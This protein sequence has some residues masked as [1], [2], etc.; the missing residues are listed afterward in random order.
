MF[1]YGSLFVLLFGVMD[2][3]YLTSCPF[4]RHMASGKRNSIPPVIRSC[5]MCGDSERIGQCFGPATCC[6]D[7]GCMIGKSPLTINCRMES[8]SGQ[9]C[10][11]YGALSCSVGAGDHV[12]QGFCSTTGVCCSDDVCVVSRKCEG[13]Q[14]ESAEEGVA[15]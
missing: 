1:L 2:A 4:R 10:I 6:F 12:R 8:V 13:P 11:P 5:A 7:D 9:P 14:A 15:P 3:C